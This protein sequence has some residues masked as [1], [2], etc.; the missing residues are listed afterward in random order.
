M[1]GMWEVHGHFLGI[2]TANFDEIAKTS[3]AVMAARCAKDA[4]RALQAGFTSVRE[5]GG[6]GVHVAKTVNEGS[7][8][9]PHIYGAGAALS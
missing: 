6:W 9:G 2:R 4:E 7:V 5:V 1:P 8:D 3:V